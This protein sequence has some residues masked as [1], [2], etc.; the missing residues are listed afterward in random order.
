MKIPKALYTVGDKVFVK[1]PENLDASYWAGTVVEV[2]FRR[3]FGQIE[4]AIADDNGTYD[5]YTEKWLSQKSR[6]ELADIKPDKNVK[7]PK[8]GYL[9]EGYDPAECERLNNL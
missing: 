1:C 7:A 3:H 5:G 8:Y 6:I 2:S 4:Y 9:T